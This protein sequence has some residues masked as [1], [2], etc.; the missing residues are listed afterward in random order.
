MRSRKH[1]HSI[2]EFCFLECKRYTDTA[3]VKIRV[4]GTNENS[5]TGCEVITKFLQ[6]PPD[7]LDIEAA[8]ATPTL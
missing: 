4:R 7:P 2:A 5:G 3:S 1:H 6:I 8:S